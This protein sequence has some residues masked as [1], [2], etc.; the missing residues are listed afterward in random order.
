[1]TPDRIQR[2]IFGVVAILVLLTAAVVAIRTW[3]PS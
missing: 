3:W 2:G 1:M